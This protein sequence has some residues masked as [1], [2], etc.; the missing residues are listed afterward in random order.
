[1]TNKELIQTFRDKC[2]SK[3]SVALQAMIDGLNHQ[4]QR[5]DFKIS[6]DTFGDYDGICYGCAVT[7][8]IQQ[9]SGV[10]LSDSSITDRVDRAIF[11]DVDREDLSYFENYIDDA[12]EGLLFKLFAYMG[13][14][15]SYDESY[16][17]NWELTTRN[18][19]TELPKVQ[20]F[21]DMLKEEGY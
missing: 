8:A 12:R 18:W 21:V 11:L 6:M 1:M 17:E 14:E 4:H 9:L 19:Q 7:C 2:H 13:Q 15:E 16:D 3:V 5:E 10:N 20:K